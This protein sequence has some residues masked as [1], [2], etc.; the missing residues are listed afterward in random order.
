MSSSKPHMVQLIHQ[1]H[2]IASKWSLKVASEKPSFILLIVFYLGHPC[3]LNTNKTIQ[4]K[5]AAIHK[6]PSPI[7]KIKLMRFIGLLNFHWKVILEL[8]ANME[9]LEEVL[10]D[11]FIF[12]W[13]IELETPCQ[14]KTIF[15]KNVTLTFPNT[16][17]LS[18]IL[19]ILL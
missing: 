10:L 12:Q 7:T 3:G 2:D 8:H 17:Q 9:P 6:I 15:T 13:K 4:S 19:L 11:K 1:I 16:N 14:K 18:S 5:K